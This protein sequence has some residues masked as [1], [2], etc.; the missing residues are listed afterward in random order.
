MA[1]RNLADQNDLEPENIEQ[2]NKI[3]FDKIRDL[4]NGLKTVEEYERT[5]P[6]KPTS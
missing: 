6:K 1:D 4:V 2:E 3:A 5:I